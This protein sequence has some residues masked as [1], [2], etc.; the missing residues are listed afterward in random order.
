MS[1]L[2]IF[3][4]IGIDAGNG[5][6]AKSDRRLQEPYGSHLHVLHGFCALFHVFRNI[7]HASGCCQVE[8]GS[9]D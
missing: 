4:A 7:S 2:I 9:L 8:L 5:E 1:P 6:Q 3:E